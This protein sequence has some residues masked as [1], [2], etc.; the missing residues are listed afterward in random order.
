[1]KEAWKKKVLLWDLKRVVERMGKYIDRKD[2]QLEK[3]KLELFDKNRE[4]QS[5]EQIH[6][7]FSKRVPLIL[8]RIE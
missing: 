1:M 4:L 7:Q 8:H 2:Y 6:R 3:I 5:N